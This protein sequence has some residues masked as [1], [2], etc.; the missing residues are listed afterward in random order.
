MDQ[1]TGRAIPRGHARTKSNT[2]IGSNNPARPRHN[3]SKSS[4]KLDSIYSDEATIAFIKRTLCAQQLTGPEGNR[5]RN[6]SKPL[7][8]LLPPLTSSNQVDLQLYALISI[9]I[10][11]FV[12]A[13]YSRITPD[14]EFT[15][16]VVHIIAHCTR[17]LEQRIRAVDLEVL[18]LDELPELVN[19]HVTVPSEPESLASLDQAENEAVWRQLLIQGVLSHLLPPED[20]NN[21][22]L[23]ILVTEIFAELIIGRG[24]C[25]NI[26]EGWFVWDVVTKVLAILR[27][28]EL[29][30]QQQLPASPNRLEKFGLLADDSDDGDE[31]LI[32]T[33]QNP[34]DTLSGVFWQV[35]Q[36]AF[37]AFTTIRVFLTALSDAASLPPRANSKE[38][39]TRGELDDSGSIR[40]QSTHDSTT[41]PILGMSLWSCCSHLLSL[42]LQMPWLTTMG[43]Y[44]QWL[45]ICS[46]WKV[47]YTNSRLDR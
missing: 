32:V 15:D 31:T 7:S 38:E 25:G 40:Q 29:D 12:Q 9:I 39:S 34:M 36:Y 27:P 47:G 44:I 17:G 28:P 33:R 45:L 21:P 10:K 11:D 41:R 16:Q 1:E 3:R 26:C 35:L 30:V 14:Q 8:E 24:V 42:D 19:V 37:L 5:A 46:S 6:I 23:K 13:W 22:P 20:L 2:S 18:L 43:A 4:K